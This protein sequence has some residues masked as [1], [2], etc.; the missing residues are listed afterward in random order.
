[1]FHSNRDKQKSEEFPKMDQKF[2]R[3]ISMHFFHRLGGSY[4]MRL[5]KI[6][7]THHFQKTDRAVSIGVKNVHK[8]I[9]PKM[10]NKNSFTKKKRKHRTPTLIQCHNHLQWNIQV[11][12][13]ASR[14]VLLL[15][16][17]ECCIVRNE[18][19]HKLPLL[20][21]PSKYTKKK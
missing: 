5:P 8:I 9:Q 16:V 15:F 17:T 10:T 12:F 19:E 4:S 21:V 6:I 3:S 11:F 18:G 7:I 1:M 20:F 13:F 14:K 2:M